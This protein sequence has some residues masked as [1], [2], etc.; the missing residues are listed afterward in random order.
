[1]NDDIPTAE[2]LRRNPEL[3]AKAME[4]Y[5]THGTG[6]FTGGLTGIG[7][8]SLHMVS[9]DLNEVQ[10]NELVNTA[11]EFQS[12]APRKHLIIQ[13]EQLRD[14]QE[15]IVQWAILNAGGDFWYADKSLPKVFEHEHPGGWASLLAVSTHLFSRGSVHIQ[16]NDPL[17]HPT[18]N[19]NY[20]T[21]PL[22]VEIMG[23]SILHARQ[24]MRTE[25]F[26]SKL[27]KGLDGDLIPIPGF[28]GPYNDPKTLEEAKDFVRWNC[29]TCYHPIGTAS[30][31][32][33]DEGGV[34]DT[35][36]K[37]YGTKNLRVVDA[38]IFPLHVQGN[39]MS[40]VYAVAERAAEII[41][42]ES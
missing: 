25:P 21:H 4:A 40:L 31:L 30:M 22:D 3:A 15:A 16:S 39:I 24:L 17:A 14:R 20:M 27:K 29:I 12:S 42:S 34:V 11:G 38:S 6:P 7:F 5:T 23:R 9:P 10:I 18:I 28:A 19:P 33:K 36:L 37:V 32:P 8:S 26:A 2:A 35:K 1:V 41:K 13:E